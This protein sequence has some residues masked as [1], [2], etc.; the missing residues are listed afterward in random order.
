MDGGV[1]RVVWGVGLGLRG[2]PAD[3]MSTQ[4]FEAQSACSGGDIAMGLYIGG[5]ALGGLVSTEDQNRTL[6]I[7]GWIDQSW[8]GVFLK[9]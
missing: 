3:M 7:C 8:M 5:A 6:R 2:L 1:R 4:I 9:S